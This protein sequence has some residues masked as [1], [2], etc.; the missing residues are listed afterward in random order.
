[1]CPRPSD[2]PYGLATVDGA[3]SKDRL[4]HAPKQGGSSSTMLCRTRPAVRPVPTTWSF[5]APH[6]IATRRSSGLVCS[7]QRSAPPIGLSIQNDDR[8]GRQRS[9]V[10]CHVCA[11]SGG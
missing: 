6:T 1:M 9:I 7:C 10:A 5:A 2:E 4:V 3:G 8:F 11:S